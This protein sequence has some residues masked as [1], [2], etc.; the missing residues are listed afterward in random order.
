MRPVLSCHNNFNKIIMAP[1]N[2]FIISNE[3]G[4]L[5]SLLNLVIIRHMECSRVGEGSNT[6]IR[7]V[8]G[9]NY[10]QEPVFCTDCGKKLTEEE[11]LL[12]AIFGEPTFK[13]KECF[14]KQNLP[15]CVKCG[16]II[17]RGKEVYWFE[18]PYHAAC[19]PYA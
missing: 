8:F 17:P 9:P 3:E 16:V 7:E 1:H 18:D 11:R 19:L 12:S 14:D 6:S 4:A 13:C 15:V 2:G 5:T 10:S